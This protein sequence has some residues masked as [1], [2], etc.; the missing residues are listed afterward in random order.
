MLLRKKL[1]FGLEFTMLTLL[2]DPDPDRYFV[3]ADFDFGGF[4]A[5]FVTSRHRLLSVL[6]RAATQCLRR[7][8]IRQLR[9]RPCSV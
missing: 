5:G 6:G 7:L 1:R 2:G 4:D 9:S 3:I 8:I